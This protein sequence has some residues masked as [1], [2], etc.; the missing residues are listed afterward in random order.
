M[1]TSLVLGRST[2]L[3]WFGILLWAGA[4]L[5]DP[6][7]S[8]AETN[9]NSQSTSASGF[10]TP[11][12]NDPDGDSPVMTPEQ[13]V[14][15][16]TLPEGFKAT[17][18]AA[19]PEVQNPIDMAW[20]AKGRLWVAENYTYSDRSEHFDLSLRDRV[21][22]LE[23]RNGD[24]RSDSRMVFN[25]NLQ[26][27]TSVEVGRGGVWLMCPP[28]VLFVPDANHDG[29]ADGEAQVVLDGFEVASQ[30]YHNFANGL[31]FGPDGWLYGRCGGS[32]PGRIGVPGTPD[33]QRVAI[34]GGIW[35]FD[36]A[37]SAVEVLTTGTT[38]PWGHDWNADGEL[39]F[40]NT[41]NGHLWH[42]IP[43]A[44]FTRPFTLDPN[45]HTYELIDF[46][47]DH[48]HFDRSGRW[49]DSRDG[50]ANDF[51]GGHAHC[52]TMIYQGGTWPSQYH[53]KLF[54]LNFHGR[55]ANVESLEPTG[56]GFVAK[57]EADFFIAGDPWFRG[58]ELASGPDGNV[59]VLDW[60]DT[61]ECHEHTGVH[62][63]SGRIYKIDHVT[64]SEPANAA[65]SGGEPV[66]LHAMSD[67]D[68]VDLHGS[69]NE[70]FVRQARL[71][72]QERSDVSESEL[73]RLRTMAFSGQSPANVRAFCTL[74]S[75]REWR[76]S[77]LRKMLH[78]QD[79]SMRALAVR[80][81]SDAW[82]IDD[83]W[84][85]WHASEANRDLVKRSAGRWMGE[86]LRMARKDPS[87]RIRLVL[88]STLQRLP[89]SMRAEL[90]VALVS[91]E[92]DAHDHN[93]PLMIWYGL[94]SVADGSSDQLVRVAVESKLPTVRRF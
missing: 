50:A 6:I 40:I 75:L 87:A 67:S 81:I 9:S 37:T 71:V 22:I 8:A 68:L 32:C 90:A 72:L 21:V 7:S 84:G 4:S 64:Q 20:D 65:A 62:R 74:Q 82:P 79:V 94:M 63:Q 34:E 42:G 45:R 17:V 35:R 10:P 66:D 27:L 91:H 24:G 93:L 29:V 44:H 5:H 85:P 55:R 89:I 51:G 76:E 57:H 28:Q 73:S 80:S 70:W 43:G 25:D 52:G 59:V 14:A 41:V 30:N 18:F 58:M 23:D 47:A 61:G 12:N 36:P 3:V 92:S 16:I 13:A 77:E 19:E 33:D 31:R 69:K 1:T 2:I 11:T 54:T 60:S 15:A 46:H 39:F 38:N 86:F 26:M 48:W 53:G 88:A 78:H 83:V 49:Q 56:A